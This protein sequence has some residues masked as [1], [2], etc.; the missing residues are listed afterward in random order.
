MKRIEKNC[1]VGTAV[2]ISRLNRKL[3]EKNLYKVF[4]EGFC[5]EKFYKLF[6]IDGMVVTVEYLNY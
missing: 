6:I 5:L 3:H 4:K 2:E 1:V